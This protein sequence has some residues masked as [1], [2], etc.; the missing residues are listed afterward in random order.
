M[1]PRPAGPAALS[2]RR[3]SCGFALVFAMCLGSSAD[4][5]AEPTRVLRFATIAPEGTAWARL[6]RSFAREIEQETRGEVQAR[7][8]FGGIAGDEQEMVAR[9]RRGQ[10]DGIASA[11][12]MCQ[13][14]APTLRVI[15]VVGLF[16]SREEALY[17]L[18]RLTPRVDKEFADAGFTNLGEA[19]FGSDVI[20]SRA[21]LRTL[22]E[23]RRARLWVW[24]LDDVFRTELPA[25]GMHMTPTSVE[26]A[27]GAFEDGKIDGF[28]GIPSAALAYQWST[29]ARYFSDLRV[30]YLMGCLV[31]AQTAFDPL[32]LKDQKAV[33][34]AAGKLMRQM[35]DMG[36]QQDA[37]LMKSLFEKQGMHRVEV[38]KGFRTEFLD[39]ARVAR[40]RLGAKLTTPELLD[41]IN[42]WL[43]DYRSD[44]R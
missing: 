32:A 13:R 12:M 18:G 21:P 37:A 16:Q 9:V 35:E 1:S 30:S 40:Q 23:L 43:A 33:R 29:R 28:I 36:E 14:L 26:G 4:A 34:A 24:D 42:G 44:H 31:V 19:G 8:Y 7:W 15:R 41:E 10:L 3:A 6:A 5:H 20:F 2:V 27:L 39:A 25:L 38:S 22:D 17:V 11:G